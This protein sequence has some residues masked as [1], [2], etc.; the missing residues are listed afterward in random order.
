MDFLFN[1]VTH[2]WRAGASQPSR[3]TGIIALLHATP[4]ASRTLLALVAAD[5]QGHAVS[6]TNIALAY[7]KRMDL[8]EGRQEGV[9]VM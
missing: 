6:C 1:R 3:T 8:E 5:T 4:A 9:F 7:Q 2:Y